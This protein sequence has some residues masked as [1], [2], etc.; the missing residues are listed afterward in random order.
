MGLEWWSWIAQVGETLFV[1]VLAPFAVRQFYL[2]RKATLDQTLATIIS[3]VQAEH[4]RESRKLLFDLEDKKGISRLPISQWDEDWK[5]AADRVSQAFNS[6]A[7]IAQQD[8]RLQN[9]WIGPT[10]RAI[11]QSWEIAQPRIRQRRE[12]LSDLWQEFE[13]LAGKAKQYV[14]DSSQNKPKG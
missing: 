2:Q 6:A 12:Q 3:W 14:P 7:I 5:Q 4:I 10:R 13:W 8:R 9:I 1:I 11:L